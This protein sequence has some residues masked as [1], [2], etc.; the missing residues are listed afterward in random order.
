MWEKYFFKMINFSLYLQLLNSREVR[1]IE[2]MV[3][4]LFFPSQAIIRE[5]GG[6]PII[7]SKI[8]S[9]NHSIKEKALNA[10]NNLSVNVE[11]QIKI[12]V[13]F[14]KSKM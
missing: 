8:N 6:I 7:G 4:F 3:L 2:V 14:V 1:H 10:L 13:S 11:N 5:L 12:K 9:P